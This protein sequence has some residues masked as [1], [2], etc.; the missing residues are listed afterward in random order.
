MKF[1][2]IGVGVA[3]L[4][5][6]VIGDHALAVGDDTAEALRGWP[7]LR[8]RQRGQLQEHDEDKQMLQGS[9]PRES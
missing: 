9:T 8:G 7:R 4:H 5:L 2:H 1:H 3:H 6:L